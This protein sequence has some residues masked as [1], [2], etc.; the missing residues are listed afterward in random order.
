MDNE[1]SM[2]KDHLSLRRRFGKYRTVIPTREEW[3]KDWLKWLRK[4]QVWF[5]DG[6]CNQLGTGAG[7]CKYQSKIQ[8]HISLGQ[9][10]TAFQAEVVAIL[11]Y[12]TSCLRKRLVKEQIVICTD[13][14]A[15]VAALAASGTKSLLVADCI[16][17]P[18]VLSEVNQVAIMWV[19]GHS[20][21]Q[22]NKTADRLARERE[23]ERELGLD[24]SV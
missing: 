10:A 7:I 17:K 22:Q 12:V 11:D 20:G 16:E 6:A 8:W 15:A 3:Y 2:I 1:F 18:T 4:G 14:Q 21:I 24:S 23:R 5:R 19:P 9:D 13:S